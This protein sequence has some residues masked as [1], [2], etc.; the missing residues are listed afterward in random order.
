MPIR[1]TPQSS[2][3]RDL[4]HGPTAWTYCMDLLEQKQSTST[5]KIS[6]TTAR[7]NFFVTILLQL[8]KKFGV[9]I[10]MT[11]TNF[12]CVHRNICKHF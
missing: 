8:G 1:R 12:D 10:P 3:A 7:C 2:A 6:K 11:L 5:H 4:L 9:L